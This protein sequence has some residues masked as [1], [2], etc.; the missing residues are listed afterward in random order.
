MNPRQRYLNALG[1]KPVDRVPMRLAGIE[2]ENRAAA[3]ECDDP[4]RRD[5][6]LRILD[7]T[8]YELRVPASGN[9]M[10]MTPPQ[11]IRRET[12]DLGGGDRRVIFTINTPKSEL[13]CVRRWDQS[14]H[15]SWV[16]KYPVETMEDIEAIASVPSELP[17][18]ISPADPSGRPENFDERGVAVA[19]VSSP[20][21][22]V[23][24]MMDYEWFL[25]LALT[26]QELIGELTEICHTRILDVLQVLLSNPDPGID[27]IWMGGSEWVTPP[28]ASPRLYDMYVQ[29]QERSI[30]EYIHENSDALCHIHCHGNVRH[31]LPRTIERGGD[32]TEPVEPP[33][34]GDI[35]MAEAKAVANGRITLGGNLECRILCNEGEEATEQAVREAFEGGKHRVV[36]R[37]TEAPTPRMS[38][39]EFDNYMRVVDVWEELSPVE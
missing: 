24:G 12:E 25:E 20:F 3:L 37:P 21:V 34:D 33:P 14:A 2:F 31:A 32:Y 7:E 8:I 35:T 15:T 38:E 22:C 19:R 28:M 6:G 29:N 4:R 18:D 16:E 11:Y 36:L 26:E 39:R 27:V 1:G 13:T 23:A 10:L 5:I 9:R 30:I 17:E